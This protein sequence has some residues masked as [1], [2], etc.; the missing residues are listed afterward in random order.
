MV[1]IGKG[2]VRNLASRVLGLSLRR[3]SRD[4]RA[5]HGHPV[6]IAET[7]VDPSRFS[8][9]CYRASNWRMLGVNARV[10]ALAGRRGELAR[11]RAA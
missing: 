10:H 6:L 3:L 5:A 2:E 1:L 4:M 7:F 8:G 11:E 9:A